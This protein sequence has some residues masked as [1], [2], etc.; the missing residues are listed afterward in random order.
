MGKA[1]KVQA[2][3]TSEPETMPGVESGS[4]TRQK[5]RQGRAPRLAAARS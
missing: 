3:T 2:K 1:L 5:T 4:V